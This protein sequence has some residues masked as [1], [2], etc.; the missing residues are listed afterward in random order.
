MGFRD[1]VK[2]VSQAAAEA[3]SKGTERARTQL[4]RRGIDVDGVIPSPGE[5]DSSV[6]SMAREL[7][8]KGAAAAQDGATKARSRIDQSGVDL[9]ALSSS[10]LTGA[11]L[12]N[13]HGDVAAW[14]VARAAL[15]PTKVTRGVA[16]SVAREALRQRRALSAGGR[17]PAGLGLDSFAG[18]ELD[19]GFFSELVDWIIADSGVEDTDQG[20]AQVWFYLADSGVDAFARRVLNPEDR[21]SF[22]AAVA[23]HAFDPA[24]HVAVLLSL[25]PASQPD[26]LRHL[27]TLRQY[28]VQARLDSGQQLHEGHP[29]R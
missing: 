27:D 9:Q 1:R 8:G 25:A 14:R 28:A 3:A 21:R 22:Q 24:R 17:A 26:L 2:A 29:D 7:A 5:G 16:M 6:R 20:R 4:E 10:A 11:G 23:G 19:E 13:S 18:L 12:T 15:R